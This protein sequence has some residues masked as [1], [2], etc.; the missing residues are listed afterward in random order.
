[1]QSVCAWRCSCSRPSITSAMRYQAVLVRLATRINHTGHSWVGAASGAHGAL[2]I[3]RHLQ[4]ARD[5]HPLYVAGTFVDLADAHI[6]VDALD[7]EI[8]EVTVTA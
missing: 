4:T 6:A 3:N 2:Y 7:R 1:M 5:H 8:L